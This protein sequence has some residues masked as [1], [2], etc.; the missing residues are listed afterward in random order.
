M[1]I[2]HLFY[3]EYFMNIILSNHYNPL[4]EIKHIFWLIP[5]LQ[6]C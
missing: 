6:A 1:Y 3:L 2:K 5:V 4:L